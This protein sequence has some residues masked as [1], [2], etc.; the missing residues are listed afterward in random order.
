M[1][2]NMTNNDDL[3]SRFDSNEVS[4]TRKVPICLVLDVS[5][6]MGDRDGTRLTKIE[7]LSKN[8]KDFLT[9]VRT[10]SKARA[11][12]DLSVISFGHEVTVVNGYSNIESVRETQ[13]S[14]NGSTPM[15]AA[16]KKALDLLEL[17]RTYYK[18]K[19]IE[20]YKPILILMTDG[21]ATDDYHES[22]AE[23][24]SKVKE[25]R[26]KVL[27]FIIGQN[28]KSKALAAFSPVYKPKAIR[29]S[30][31]FKELFLL[32]SQSTANPAVDPWDNF[33]GGSG[34]GETV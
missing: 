10:N 21:D 1:G 17:R 34:E 4:N 6:S 32:L 15:G 27:P 20:H 7:E 2:E 19:G 26:L 12:C 16:M 25:K 24:S 13:F 14:A 31:D 30:D 33:M 11:M 22:A 9:F 28:N 29:S 3:M 23:I 18:D 5:G 8:Y